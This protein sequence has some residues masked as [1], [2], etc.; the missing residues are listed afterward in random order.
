MRFC[1]FFLRFLCGVGTVLKWMHLF[2][3]T[4][5]TKYLQ[6]EQAKPFQKIFMFIFI[7]RFKYRELSNV[8]P[9]ETRRLQSLQLKSMNHTLIAPEHKKKQLNSIQVQISD[10]KK[11][12]I[13]IAIY[14]IR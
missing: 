6:I 2:Q 14:R 12:S 13:S 11:K 7:F 3:I 5:K 4:P 1:F 8:S 10:R 9:A